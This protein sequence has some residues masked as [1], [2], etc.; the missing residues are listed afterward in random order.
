MTSDSPV[1]AKCDTWLRE[2]LVTSHQA[3]ANVENVNAVVAAIQ[4][5]R[6]TD[7]SP[8]SWNP[9]VR[10][11][12]RDHDT[13]IDVRFS[14]A[15]GISRG[16]AVTTTTEGV[17][18]WFYLAA[19]NRWYSPAEDSP[20][21]L[22]AQPT[23][24]DQPLP[25]TTTTQPVTAPRSTP[26]VWPPPTISSDANHQDQERFQEVGGND[27]FFGQAA[28]EF[29]KG[30][31]LLHQEDYHGA[32]QIF[33]SAKIHHGKPSSVLEN[34]IGIAFRRLDDHQKAIDHFTKAIEIK[35]NPTGRINRALSYIATGQ[36]TL[37]FQDTKRALD[38]DP[39]SADGFHTNAEAHA[40]LS[41]CHQTSGD[42]AS[43]IEHAKAAL[44]LMEENNYSATALEAHVGN[45]PCLSIELNDAYTWAKQ[46][47]NRWATHH[48]SQ[49]IEPR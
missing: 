17:P 7:C 39:E 21:F 13:N 44:S 16:A 32:L 46:Y 42:N 37:T 43:A 14:T 12:S 48:Y 22:A 28:T 38:M 33:Q 45:R 3:T 40:A 4:D 24:T 5:Q 34:Q 41:T 8:R 35:D 26:Q 25:P 18:R 49:A 31:G 19:E 27:S 11:V 47:A 23:S 15:G 36:C 2:Q 20:P 30:K 9:L 29:K 10:N 6:A 1:L